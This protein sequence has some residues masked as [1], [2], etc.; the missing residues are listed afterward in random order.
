LEVKGFKLNRS[1][2]EYLHCH[3]SG[4]E[5]GVENEVVI[6]GVLIPRVERFNYL[7]SIIQGNGKSMR[8]LTNR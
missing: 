1:K 6:G 3:F 4:G 5:G 2:T 8:T 7:G